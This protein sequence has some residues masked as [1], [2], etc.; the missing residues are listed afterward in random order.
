M[1]LQLPQEAAAA[2]AAAAT[3]HCAVRTTHDEFTSSLLFCVC[4]SFK[5]SVT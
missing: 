1:S 4:T 5:L 2:A 3:G